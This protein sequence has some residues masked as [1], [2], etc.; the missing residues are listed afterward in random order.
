MLVE[1]QALRAVAVLLVVV[2]HLWPSVLPGGYVGVD[3]FFAISGFLITSHLLKEVDRD[4]TLSLAGFWARRARRLLPASLTTLIFCAVATIAFV[5]EVHWQAFLADI[6]SSTLYVQNWHLAQ[7]SVDYLASSDAPSPVQHFWSLSAEEQFYIAWPILILLATALGGRGGIR[8]GDAA[9][10]HLRIAGVLGAVTAGSLVASILLTS[11]DPAQAYFITPTRAWE[12]GAGGL[13]ALAGT[14]GRGMVV[15]RAL[16]AWAGL[17]AIAAAALLYDDG[18]A[19]PGYTA[20][21]PVLGGLAV[22]QAG[23]PRFALSPLAGYRLRVVQFLGDVS[24]S[25]YLWHWP[26]LIL[27]PYVLSRHTTDP[28][29]GGIF[30]VSILAAWASKVLIEDPVRRS[31]VLTRGRP[32]LTFALVVA[33]TAAVVAVAEAGTHHVT[34]KLRAA[35]ASTAKTV[36]EHPRCFGAASH[37]PNHRCVNPA[38]RHTV[39]PSPLEARNEDNPAC[40]RKTKVSSVSVCEFGVPPSEARR[41]FALIGDSHATHWRAGLEHV[42]ADEKW[43]GLSITR[44]GCP[45]SRAVYV[46][47]EP[48][49][50]RCIQWNREVPG[51]LAKHPEVDTVFVSNIT[52]GKVEVPRGKTSAQAKL[53]GYRAG[54]AAF[55][56]TVKHVIVL[57]DTPKVHTDTLDCVDAAHTAGEAAGTACSVL[58]R[59]AIDDD[60]AAR[61]ARQIGPPRAQVVDMSNYLCGV[62]RCD[63]VI[64]GVLV[65]KD[66]H[67][68]TREF[69]TTLGPY[70]ERKITHLV[71]AWR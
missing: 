22:I 24:Y 47:P 17:A 68:L 35:E 26:L 61:V 12:F 1:I 53:D 38:L 51:M 41:T 30:A 27:A 21:L 33:S 6:R 7:T 45:Y 9:P 28:I 11:S 40:T 67:H 46:L 52:G 36:K 4:R 49:R 44:T 3:V 43:H 65:Y 62:R 42:A 16:L 5:P 63:V 19:F 60:P 13:L 64:G 48:T 56:K 29:R 20:L 25:L 15:L 37:D 34:Q 18:T 69:S 10:R 14:T 2:Y 58:R 66:V 50:S 54:W 8:V 55:P 71:S 57:R 39:V 23:A 32:V 31:T 70:L 59:T